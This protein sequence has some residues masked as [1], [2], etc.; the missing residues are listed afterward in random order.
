MATDV[1]VHPAAS[2]RLLQDYLAQSAGRL[3]D[4]IAL[5]SEGSRWTYAEIDAQSNALAHFL[6]QRGVRRGDRVV[7]FLDNTPEAVVAFWAV[8][9]ADAVVCVI[10]PQTKAEKLNYLLADCRPAALLTQSWHEPVFTEAVIG[11]PAL[12]AVVMAR[13][14]DAAKFADRPEVVLWEAALAAG[15]RQCQPARENIDIDLAV[16]VYTSGSTGEPKG[17]MLSHRNMVAAATSITTYLENVED[18]VILCALPLSFDYGLYQMIMAFRVGARLVL[19]KSFAFP[20]EFLQ[21]VVSEGVTGLPGVPTMFAMIEGMKHLATY[22]FSA[23]R[24][25]T[26]TAAALTVDRLLRLR[27]IF[28]A[29]RVYSMYGLTECKRCTYLPPDEIDRH[30]ASVG[31]AIPNT[32]LWLVDECGNRLGPNEVGQLVVRGAT[33][34]QGYWEKPAAT[35]RRLRPGPLPGEFVLYT[36]DY[37]RLDDDGF[38]YFVGRMDDMIKSRGE[39]VAPK[40]VEHTLMSIPGISDAAVIGVPDDLLGQTVKAFVVLGEGMVLTPQT[41]RRECQKR[42]EAFMVPA[43]VVVV[44]AL[45]RNANG[46]INKT[47]LPR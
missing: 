31:I 32:E 37:C 4:K 25:V 5:V 24:Y 40:E 29:S 3:P 47:E 15:S 34:M 22:D 13:A 19:E 38:L 17:V 46:K 12:A 20:A 33:V 45:P 26:N 6:R 27:Q 9:K 30:P 35:A 21:L 42:L 36:G 11:Q 18:D 28:P 1:A 8:L 2:A 23:V 44:A 10:N 43:Q 39:K 14:P 41:I 7:L 16:I